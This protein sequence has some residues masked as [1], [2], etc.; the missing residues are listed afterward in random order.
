MAPFDGLVGQ[1]PLS[2]S[3][4]TGEGDLHLP[5]T[6]QHQHLT[7]LLLIRVNQHTDHL[8]TRRST[9]ILDQLGG[10]SGHR[11]Q[12]ATRLDAGERRLAT[13]AAHST[14]RSWPRR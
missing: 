4:L 14:L 5:L 2:Q 13:L 11:H 1:R 8:N 6:Q 10:N 12:T 9:R 7:Q 3:E